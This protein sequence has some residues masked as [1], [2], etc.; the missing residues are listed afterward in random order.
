MFDPHWLLACECVLVLL[1]A[2]RRFSRDAV[3]GFNAC[4]SCGFENFK[5]EQICKLCGARILSPA[6]Q[7]GAAGATAVDIGTSLRQVEKF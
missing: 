5:R 7:T 2:C 1:L 3:L 4:A 6:L